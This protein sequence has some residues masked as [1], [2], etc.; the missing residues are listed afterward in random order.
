MNE[1]GNIVALS[2]RT[3]ERRKWEER[4]DI[5]IQKKK[6]ESRR[7]NNFRRASAVGCIG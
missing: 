7:C 4:N 1:K 6:L 2:S 3:A 5:K